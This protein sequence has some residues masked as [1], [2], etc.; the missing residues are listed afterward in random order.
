[1]FIITAAIN[2]IYQQFLAN[3]W[4]RNFPEA[5]NKLHILFGQIPFHPTFIFYFMGKDISV[6]DRLIVANL[7][8]KTYP[9]SPIG[10]LLEMSNCFTNGRLEHMRRAWQEACAKADKGF[11]FQPSVNVNIFEAEQG[12]EHAAVSGSGLG[13]K[14]STALD[15]LSKCEM[16]QD[17]TQVPL[18]SG[19]N[20]APACSVSTEPGEP[21]GIDGVALNGSLGG[22]T[23]PTVYYFRYGVHSGELT[24]KTPVRELP[25]G[26]F[27][28][29]RDTGANLYHR[30]E[31]NAANVM[32][33][34]VEPSENDAGSDDRKSQM[35]VFAMKL[36]WPFGKDRN[37]LDG[38]GIIDLLFGW[39][40]PAQ[41][42]GAIDG[43]GDQ[44][45]YPTPEYHGEAIDLRDAV[46]GVTYRSH[47]LDPKDFMPVVWIHGRTGT[48]IYPE[49]HDDLTAWAVTDDA[50]LKSFCA[51]GAWHHLEFDLPGRSSQWTF[52]GSNTDEM[53]SAMER[54]T[55]APIQT[56]QRENVGGNICL[57][58]VHGGELNTP[59]GAIEIAE[60]S[61]TYRSRSLLGPG[62]QAELQ[63]I[64]P[65]LLSDPASLTDGTIG[66]IERYWFRAISE[67]GP[68]D[69]VWRL[70]DRA[71]ICS[72][73]IHQ[74]VLA[75]AQG[76]EIAVSDDGTVFSDVWSGA[77][78]DVP[79]DPGAWK[80]AARNG[81]LARVVV[82]SS[83]MP[84]RYIR[85]RV[86]SGYRQHAVGLDAFEVFGRGL[87][88]MPSPEPF[89]F[90][91]IV[92]GL[93]SAEVCFA[94]LMAENADGIFEGEV[95]E[96][97]RPMT[98]KP[99]ILSAHVAQRRKDEAVI[100]VRTVAMGAS[101]SLSVILQSDLGEEIVVPVISVGKWTV[102]R[103]AR[104]LVK[105]L[106][107]GIAYRGVCRAENENGGSEDYPF[108]CEASMHG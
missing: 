22:F 53:G 57:A 18:Q 58:F 90:S 63:S 49:A 26:L 45:G 88:F 101:T 47:D 59:E 61:L 27:G 98:D 74:N 97:H 32:F 72:F 4:Q 11:H 3:V 80:D 55:Y 23:I 84:A 24:H 33:S 62:Q 92:T 71:E 76:L 38:I 34:E 29:V 25:A 36:E 48:A 107:P 51:D 37:H 56:I 7:Y 95:V 40:T 6:R 30:I 99:H 41:S 28:K 100:A 108:K 15:Q 69:L 9:A 91:E 50:D 70:R 19:K 64:P 54:Y 79:V 65:D 2:D 43:A 82:L 10:Y 1:M 8:K 67:N 77:L 106:K 17:T 5:I 16:P 52:C 46:F 66:D 102:P 21:T 12:K 87:P 105:G 31:A 60:L 96:I 35:P 81:G 42:R 78:D 93:P 94:Q 73:K 13:D 20:V 75:P 86:L 83:G 85:L 103:D 68:S 89:T 44:A 104:I 14:L 39:G